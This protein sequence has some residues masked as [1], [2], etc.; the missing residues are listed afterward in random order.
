MTHLRKSI[1]EKIIIIFLKIDHGENTL[2]TE[3]TAPRVDNLIQILEDFSTKVT[4]AGRK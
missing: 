1:P 2:K 4:E 3:K